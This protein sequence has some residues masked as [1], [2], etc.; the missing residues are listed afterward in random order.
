MIGVL[1]ACQPKSVTLPSE[2]VNKSIV[3]EA[4]ANNAAALYGDKIYSFAGLGA[5]K[6]WT[7]VHAKAFACSTVTKACETLPPLPDGKGRLAATAQSVGN[8]I[9][10]F[11]GYTVAEDHTE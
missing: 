6:S 2:D 8:L 3:N 9:Y 11:G 4:V 10:I 7:D 1:A 5:G